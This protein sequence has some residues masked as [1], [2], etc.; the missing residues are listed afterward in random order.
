[1][2]LH[3]G[4]GKTRTDPNNYRAISLLPVIFK[5]FEKLFLTRLEKNKFQEKLHPL[6]HGFQKGKSCKMVSFIYQEAVNYTLER[7]DVIFTCFMDALKAFDR[8]WISGLLHNFLRSE[9]TA[10]L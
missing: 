5:I 10:K 9:Y 6:Q 7:H 4:N 8:T 2:T 1:M 3:K